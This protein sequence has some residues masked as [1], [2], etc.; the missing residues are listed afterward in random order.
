MKSI[1]I[2]RFLNAA[3]GPKRTEEFERSK[4]G[5]YGKALDT[6][7][8]TVSVFWEEEARLQMFTKGTVVKKVKVVC[9]FLVFTV[10][11]RDKNTIEGME[12][13]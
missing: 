4:C 8:R 10:E 3:E 2:L 5:S 13:R 7:K 9:S 12:Q 6:V 1:K 11:W